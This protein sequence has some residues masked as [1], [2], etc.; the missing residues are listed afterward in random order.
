MSLRL[1][2]NIMI[3]RFFPSGNDDA[4]GNFQGG[5][6]R[7]IIAHLDY[8]RGLGMTGIMLTPFYHTA[9]YHGYHIIS[10]DKVDPHFGTKAD[11][12]DLVCETHRRGMTITA[13]FVANYCHATSPLYTDGNHRDWFKTDR[14]GRQQYYA[15]MPDLPLFDTDKRQV[16]E[17]LTGKV[18]ELCDIGFDT[19]RFDHATEASYGFWKYLKSTIKHHYPDVEL[20]GEVRG[21]TD[22]SPHRPLR[23]LMN[24]MRYGAQEARQLE[25]TDIFDGVLDFRF[26][27][28]VTDA[29]KNGEKLTQ[30][31]ILSRRIKHH[32]RHYPSHFELWLF[33]DNHDLNRILFESNFD[34]AR[35]TDAISFSSSWN[36][37]LIILYGTETRR[38]NTQT[39]FDN[40]PHAYERVRI[41]LK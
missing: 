36:R 2:Y 1:I 3:D 28:L 16:Q 4:D 13:D 25:Y 14:N 11:L 23:Y 20:I 40:T 6:I 33:L 31:D 7:D 5:C 10:F 41:S 30:N 9:A 12:C 27:E 38:T 39:I 24:K 32:F 26:R 18:L 8:I 34:F 22:F 15:G 19:I 37:P 29:I 35:V 21:D 17:Y